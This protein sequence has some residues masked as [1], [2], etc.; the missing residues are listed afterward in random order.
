MDNACSRHMMGDRSKFTHLKI[1]NRGTISFGDDSNAKIIGIG[2]IGTN[3]SIKEAF[4][5][6]GLKFNLLSVSQLY[7]RNNRVIFEPTHCEV[8]S[9]HDNSFYWQ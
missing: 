9:L 8:Q 1:K 6:T 3:A 7:D 4:L 2:T 5:V